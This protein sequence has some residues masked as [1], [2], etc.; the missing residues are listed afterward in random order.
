MRS[1]KGLKARG[2]FTVSATY[3]DGRIETA[4]IESVVGGKLRLT[5]KE[6]DNVCVVCKETGVAVQT[7]KSGD[8]LVWGRV[9]GFFARGGV[10][11]GV[12][13]DGQSLCPPRGVG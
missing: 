11:D 12:G 9:L 2:N 5:I 8:K 13:R 3:Y 7:V 10:S 1:F 4:E 6:Q